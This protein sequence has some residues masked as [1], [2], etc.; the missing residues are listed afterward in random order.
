MTMGRVLIIGSTGFLGGALKMGLSSQ[1]Y[2]IH[3][4]NRNRRTEIGTQSVPSHESRFKDEV[5]KIKPDAIIVCNWDGVSKQQRMDLQKQFENVRRIQSYLEVAVAEHVPT[6]IALGSQAEGDGLLEPIK[7]D[8]LDSNSTPY[9][10]AKTVLSK[11]LFEISKGTSTKVLWAR[12]FSVFG[13]GDHPDSL[14]SK[15]V[16]AF[17]ENKLY[18]IR[19]P[20]LEW[21]YLYTSDFVSAIDTLLT[22]NLVQGVVNVANPSMERLENLTKC[23]LRINPRLVCQ[24]PV[25]QEESETPTTLKPVVEKLQNAGWK[26]KFKLQEA[27]EDILAKR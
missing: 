18:P 16:S 1:K 19:F 9:S 4:F 7:E 10:H 20:E 13:P 14:V 3:C 17:Q 25:L 15:C 24:G 22:N 8:V 26:P 6:F 23:F 12:V 11:S 5:S 21:S 2:D 27:I